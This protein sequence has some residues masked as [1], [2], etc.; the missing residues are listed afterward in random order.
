MTTIGGFLYVMGGDN[1]AVDPI[2][3]AASAAEQD[4]VYFS[5]IN[6]QNGSL[7]AWTNSSGMGK[8]REKFTAVAAGDAVVVTGGLYSGS[9]G[10]SESR[11]AT[12]NTDG[13]LG[14]FNGATGTNTISS[15]IRMLQFLQPF[16]R[17]FRG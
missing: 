2:T 11:Y 17:L 8:G 7:G 14:S 16:D 1:T 6:L 9:P 15:W 10:S 5:A 13:S 4:N 3:N 12:V